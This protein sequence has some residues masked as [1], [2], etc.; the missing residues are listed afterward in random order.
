MEAVKTNSSVW[1]RPT[2]GEGNGVFDPAAVGVRLGAE[3]LVGTDEGS[4]VDVLVAVPQANSA[5]ATIIGA[6]AGDHF[7]L[8]TGSVMDGDLVV[9]TRAPMGRYYLGKDVLQLG[10]ISPEVVEQ[11]G[12]RK[13]QRGEVS[14]VRALVSRNDVDFNDYEI[15]IK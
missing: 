14:A 7:G 12:A 4:T 6:A 3:G 2:C 10:R 9:S 11:S 1:Y 13:E 15:V 5:P 8:S